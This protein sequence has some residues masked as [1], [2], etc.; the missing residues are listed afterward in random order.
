[1]RR[2]TH[3][4]L[5]WQQKKKRP[6][7]PPPPPRCDRKGV[8]RGHEQ[9][10]FAHFFLP[11]FPFFF[12]SSSDHASSASTAPKSSTCSPFFRLPPAW[13][14]SACLAC[15]LPF[16]PPPAFS[17]SSLATAAAAGGPPFAPFFCGG[18]SPALLFAGAIAM[19]SPL[20][21]PASEIVK[22]FPSD[23]SPATF[24]FLTSLLFT[25]AP[26]L[27]TKTLSP[28]FSS[29]VVTIAK[30]LP[31]PTFTSTI[32]CPFFFMPST[33]IT[34]PMTISPDDF[35]A[36][37][38]SFC[39]ERDFSGTPSLSSSSLGFGTSA[40]ALRKAFTWPALIPHSSTR[41]SILPSSIDSLDKSSILLM[42]YRLKVP[43][44]S[45]SSMASSHAPTGSVGFFFSFPSS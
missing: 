39:A 27:A 19:V 10:G 20:P 41:S 18:A 2:V 38:F 28:S 36:A 42:L 32:K 13:A 33:I 24:S 15:F 30:G 17:S 40:S 37:S 9:T 25:V 12:L 45:A 4:R 44:S 26:S 35:P 23:N 6:T 14:G 31:W 7:A 8:L 1:M 29:S 43:S 3:R 5:R 11:F 21:Q 34:S 16:F 22:I